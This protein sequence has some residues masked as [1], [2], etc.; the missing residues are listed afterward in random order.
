MSNIL[1]GALI[2]GIWLV[3]LFFGKS[4]G[5]SMILF[6]VP[7]TYYIIYILEKNDKIVYK[8]AKMLI[9]PIILLSSTY[10]IY[11][12][13]FFRKL[14]IFVIPI[15][16]VI[17]IIRLLGEKFM[18]RTIIDEVIEIV[19]K[20]IALVSNTYEN[21]VN[22][23]KGKLKL[24]VD[25]EN[26]NK[27]GS[28]VKGILITI[29][30]VIVIMLLL[31]SADEVF[32]NIFGEMLIK[33]INQILK[34]KISNITI[35]IIFVI[36]AFF[37]F[38]GFFDYILNRFKIDGEITTKLEVKKNTLT[39]KMVLGAL[40]CIYLIFCIIQI[41]SLFMRDVNINYAQYARQGFFQLMVVS[42]INL[43]TILIAKKSDKSEQKSKYITIM[44]V[45]MIIF[46]FIIVISSV[47][48]MYLY[49]SAYGYT[50]LRLL[51]YCALFTETMLLIPTVMYVTDKK[52]NL[53]KVYFVIILII[54]IGMNFVN[55]DNLIAKRN[56][57]R[58]METGKIDMFYLVEQTGTDATGQMLRIMKDK[59]L[60]VSD[61]ENCFYYL[62][63]LEKEVDDEGID[64]RNFNISKLIA[65]YLIEEDLRW[66]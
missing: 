54:Y 43:V 15:L 10:F 5:V 56:V 39:V 22:V 47:M 50:L 6:V 61:K 8:K 58:Y 38:A 64:F 7:I 26:K 62:K 27:V 59:D 25:T 41:K 19:S 31:A 21:L 55:F 63:D 17:M 51:V 18:I 12:N 60:N 20:P 32:R 1:I 4:I 36:I 48:R 13:E 29:P 45:I 35:K 9:I 30:I 37:Y 2:F 11:N 46:T 66:E 3:V 52:I 40:N 53:T 33:I 28:I 65:K 34:I 23:I 16:I 24:K 44:S 14:N 49:E 57:D 42:F